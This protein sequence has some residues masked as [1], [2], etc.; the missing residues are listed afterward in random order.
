MTLRRLLT[1]N[2]QTFIDVSVLGYLSM[3]RAEQIG[4]GSIIQGDGTIA[5]LNDEIAAA[6]WP[7][8]V[9]AQDKIIIDGRFWIILGSSEVCEGS[10]VIGHTISVRGG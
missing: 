1:A 2:P 4:V 6:G 8:P 7:G 5:I 9:R 3:F 10:N